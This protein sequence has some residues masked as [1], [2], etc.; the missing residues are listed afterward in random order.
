MILKLNLFY[1]RNSFLTNNFH[2]NQSYISLFSEFTVSLRHSFK[3]Y[4]F[5]LFILLE[6]DLIYIYFNIKFIEIFD[7][8]HSQSYVENHLNAHRHHNYLR[9]VL[10]T[11][12]LNV[13]NSQFM[14]LMSL[15]SS[16]ISLHFYF[17]ADL[18]NCLIFLAPLH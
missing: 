14:F 3:V 16:A 1:F 11:V 17:K 5:F 13:F 4:D 6:L 7:Y 12:N 9:Y 15:L 18:Q 10:M 8:F 2:L